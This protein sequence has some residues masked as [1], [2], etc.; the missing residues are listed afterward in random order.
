MAADGTIAIAQAQDHVVRFFSAS[1]EPVGQFGGRGSGPG[2]FESPERIGWTGDSLWIHDGPLRRATYLTPARGLSRIVTLNRPPRP[3]PAL[4]PRIGRII[5][6]YPLAMFSGGAR[7]ELVMP[8]GEGSF[9]GTG[10]EVY[11]TAVSDSSELTKIVAAIQVGELSVRTDIGTAGVPFANR[12]AFDVARDGTRAGVAA[13]RI[14]GGRPTVE[15]HAFGA[16]GDTLY[17]RSFP[18]DLVPLP[19]AVRDSVIERFTSRIPSTLGDAVRARGAE[20][21]HYPPLHQLI[22]GRDGTVW[23]G[24]AA[25]EGQRPHLVLDPTGEPLGEIVLSERGRIAEAERQRIWVIEKDE[26]DVESLVRYGVRW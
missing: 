16:G 10:D 2:E 4:A 18:I 3:V 15:V 17:S 24:L 11:L 21:T 20:L 9:P 14:E 7:T 26:L 6:S 25:R 22:V 12:P 5:A 1:G 23:I 13:A 19:A 8:M